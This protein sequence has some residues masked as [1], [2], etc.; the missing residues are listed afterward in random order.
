MLKALIKAAVMFLNLVVAITA[1]EC[2]L[3][4]NDLI[5]LGIF[6][7]TGTAT[8]IGLILLFDEVLK[9]KR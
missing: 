2:F 6:V 5:Y 9:I 7:V 1:L 8:I 3:K 4:Y